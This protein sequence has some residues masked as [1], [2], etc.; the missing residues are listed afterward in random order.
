MAVTTALTV[1]NMDAN[2]DVWG[3]SSFRFEAIRAVETAGAT[4]RCRLRQT[5]VNGKI[6]WDSGLLAANAA[7]DGESCPIKGTGIL[8]LEVVSGAV[9]LSLYSC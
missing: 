3:P 5:D 7:S 8:Y 9:R 4:A 1:V 6:L 2:A